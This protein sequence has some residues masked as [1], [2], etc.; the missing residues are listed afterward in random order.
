MQNNIY[1]YNYYMEWKSSW[2]RSAHLELLHQLVGDGP[3]K[4]G[5]SVCRVAAVAHAVAAAPVAAAAVEAG[6]AG[7]VKA[8]PVKAGP[9]E[10]GPVKVGAVVAG[11]AVEAGAVKNVKGDGEVAG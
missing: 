1:V 5:T 10:A 11:A 8:G 7:P 6:A 4:A 3:R 9:I 2:S